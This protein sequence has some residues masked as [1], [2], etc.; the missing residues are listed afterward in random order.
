MYGGDAEFIVRNTKK[1]IHENDQEALPFLPLPPAPPATRGD[2][3]VRLRATPPPRRLATTARLRG[4]LTSGTGPHP[5]FFLES[6]ANSSNPPPQ[7]ADPGRRYWD[8]PT[9]S[10]GFT[11]PN[12]IIVIEGRVASPVNQRL[13]LR[14][15]NGIAESNMNQTSCCTQKGPLETTGLHP[16]FKLN[17]FMFVCDGA[18][19]LGDV[20]LGG[21]RERVRGA[22]RVWKRHK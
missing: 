20:S 5:G 17:M 8:R 10:V 12:G 19:V 21:L 11:V 4:V 2:R 7:R 15:G 18:M 6:D 14:V 13:H 22:G 16:F 1:W 3:W 9:G